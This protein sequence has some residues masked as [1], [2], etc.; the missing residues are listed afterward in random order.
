MSHYPFMKKCWEARSAGAANYGQEPDFILVHPEP[1][2]QDCRKMS[3]EDAIRHFSGPMYDVLFGMKVIQTTAIS[4]DEPIVLYKPEFK[5][6]N[7]DNPVI[8]PNCKTVNR[9]EVSPGKYICAFC[10]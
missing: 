10:G 9:H 3:H 5:K 1:F 6:W 2:Q 8:C 4:K 7:S